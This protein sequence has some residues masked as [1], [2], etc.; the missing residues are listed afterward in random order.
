MATAK[1]VLGSLAGVDRPALATILPTTAGTP[2]VFLDVGANVDC[3]PSNLLQFAVMGFMYAKSVL[4]MPEPRV[5]LL[6][7]GE[8]E[9]KGNTLTRETF[10]LLRDLAASTAC[11]SSATSKAAISTTAT[12][13]SSSATALWA[14]WR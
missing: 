3:E 13:T 6:S 10:P 12:S 7:I 11:A 1:M 4:H 9:T 8:E 5:G 14:M 2:C